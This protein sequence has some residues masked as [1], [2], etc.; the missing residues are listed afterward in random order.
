M[1][2]ILTYLLGGVSAIALIRWRLKKEPTT[3]GSAAWLPLWSASAKGLFRG[4]GLIAGDWTGLMPV[5]Y[6]GD[7]HALTVAP[8]GCGK[9]T[10]AII[11]NLLRQPFIFLLDPGGENTAIAIKAWRDKG[12]EF[13]ILNPWKMHQDAPWSLPANGFNPLDILDPH[14]DSFA[15]DAALLA[16]MIVVR[17]S[18]DGGSTA[19]FKD[20][21]QSA[22]RAFLM[23]IVTAANEGERNLITLRKWITSDGDHWLGLMASMLKSEVAGGLIA[24]E[25]RQMI[26]RKDQ[27]PEEFSAVIST[28]KQDTNFLDDPVMQEALATS[29]A[30]FSI[31]K[32]VREGKRLRGGIVS[33]VIPLQYLD[34]HAA[35]ARLATAVALWEMQRTP[36]ARERV[37]FLLDEF[38]AMKRM[39]RIA[40]GLATLRKFKVWLWPVVQDIN[41]LKEIYGESQWQTFISNASF[42]QWLAAADIGTAKYISELCGGGTITSESRNHFG[43]VTQNPSR[44]PLVTPEEILSMAEHKQIVQ[45]GNL[46]PLLLGKTPYWLRPSLRG[47]FNPNPYRPGTPPLSWLAPFRMLWGSAHRLLG[48]VLWPAPALI[49]AA[50]IALLFQTEPGILIEADAIVRG[51]SAKC[52]FRTPLRRLNLKFT[53]SGIQPEHCPMF[54]YK[55]RFVK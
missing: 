49:Y 44:R 39:D 52:V 19:F 41:Q 29:N 11:P 40:S 16:E 55:G 38:P 43:Q 46:K 21:A 25:A 53:Q 54:N 1:M 22:I 31:L 24:N 36:H 42:R 18:K 50:I 2:E 23:H 3:F 7:G 28:M 35:Y 8:T 14:A 15:S 10:C 17:G 37:L 9:G 47:R 48:W 13:Q 6:N 33:I 27:A 32:G 51:H 26:R 20:E 34:T 45:I 5:H 30:D 4:R 12:Y